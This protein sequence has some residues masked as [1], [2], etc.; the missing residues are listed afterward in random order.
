MSSFGPSVSD[1]QLHTIPSHRLAN[2]D[3]KEAEDAELRAAA[4]A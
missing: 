3:A 4:S 1:T 2:G